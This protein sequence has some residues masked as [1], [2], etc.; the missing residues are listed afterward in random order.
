M[1]QFGGMFGARLPESHLGIGLS[2]KNMFG[3]RRQD[4]VRFQGEEVA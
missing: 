3:N 2:Q 1:V 4:A